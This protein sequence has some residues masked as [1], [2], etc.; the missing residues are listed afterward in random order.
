MALTKQLKGARSDKPNSTVPAA[1][2]GVAVTKSA[3]YKGP[4]ADLVTVFLNGLLGL[5][6]IHKEL[7]FVITLLKGYFGGG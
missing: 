3:I 7:K 2:K 4:G 6:G 5:P 1:L